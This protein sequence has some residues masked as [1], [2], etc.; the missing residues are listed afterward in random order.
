M[1][2]T[3]K[4]LKLNRSMWNYDRENAPQH[5]SFLRWAKGHIDNLVP[6]AMG[7]FWTS[8]SDHD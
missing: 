4:K 8:E 6:V 1:S 5:E 3:C 2:T 7:L